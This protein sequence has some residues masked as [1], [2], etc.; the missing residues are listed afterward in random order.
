MCNLYTVRRSAE[1]IAAYFGG[2]IPK[3]FELNTDI[4][5]GGRGLVVRSHIGRRLIQEAGWG[6]PRMTAEVRAGKRQPEPVNLVADLT[7]PMWDEMVR[8]RRYRCL[9]PV[10]LFAEPDGVPGRKTRTWF[11]VRGEPLFAWAGFCRN[12]ELWGPCYA[13]M[14]AESNDAVRLYNPR[15]PELLHADEWERWFTCGMTDVIAI[16]QRTYPAERLGITRTDEPWVPRRAALQR[17]Q[18]SL[19]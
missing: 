6:F 19:L 12:T 13:G 4:A 3:P 16:Q 2:E 11:D 5:K 9:I 8:D 18:P 7:N 14:T 10:T 15:M 17:P 1:E